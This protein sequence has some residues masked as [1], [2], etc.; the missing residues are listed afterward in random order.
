MNNNLLY[1]IVY[2]NSY[3]FIEKLLIQI[4][5]LYLLVFFIK[6]FNKTNYKIFN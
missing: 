5:S 2:L 3:T 6:I 4:L 1:N